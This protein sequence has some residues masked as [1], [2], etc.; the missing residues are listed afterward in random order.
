MGTAVHRYHRLDGYCCPHAT[1]VGWVLLSTGFIG[2]MGTAVHRLDGVLLSPSWM[3]TTVHSYNRLDV[4]RL[5][6]VLLSPSWMGTT[7]HRYNRVD[8]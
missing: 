5:Y 6:G 7:V 3:G 8:G 1:K 2:W 4:H